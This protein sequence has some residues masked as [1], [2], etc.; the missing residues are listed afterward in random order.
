MVTA[1]IVAIK[2]IENIKPPQVSKLWCMGSQRK[3]VC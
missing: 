3:L 1:H 2:M